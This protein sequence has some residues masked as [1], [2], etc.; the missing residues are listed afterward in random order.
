MK[1]KTLKI[2]FFS[3][4]GVFSAFLVRGAVIVISA[5]KLM[6]SSSKAVGIIGGADGPTAVY[7]SS[8]I[9][10]VNGFLTVLQW[11]VFAAATALLIASSVLLIVEHK[12]NK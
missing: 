1:N 7:I 11:V 9:F 2:V 10:E 5:L 4:L 3:S 8:R 6:N 12:R